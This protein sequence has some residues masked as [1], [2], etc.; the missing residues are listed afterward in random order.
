M[1]WAKKKTLCYIDMRYVNITIFHT[2]RL[3][4]L[5]TERFPVRKQFFFSSLCFC[6][7]LINSTKYYH[8]VFIFF[9]IFF[10]CSMMMLQ[11]W[12]QVFNLNHSQNTN[13]KIFSQLAFISLPLF[14]FFSHFWVPT[15]RE[16]F[17]FKHW[18]I[19]VL[20]FRWYVYGSIVH[21][22]KFCIRLKFL[23]FF[24][25]IAVVFLCRTSAFLYYLF[26]KLND[27]L[28][29]IFK[30]THFVFA[31]FLYGTRV[32]YSI[33]PKCTLEHEFTF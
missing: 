3:Q 33:F 14:L 10:I 20:S 11:S 30:L 7:S 13:W 27:R 25:H 17:W 31:V 24:I 15:L 16:L 9:I 26:V 21:C 32:L 1:F 5:S 6:F 19:V 2:N 8:F 29:N 18:A 23:Y 12:G 4:L 22:I 28:L